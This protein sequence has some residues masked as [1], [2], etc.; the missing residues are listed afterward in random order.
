M[1]V[2]LIACLAAVIF[3]VGGLFA[4]ASVQKPAGVAY[5]T[6][7]TR[8]TP[9]WSWRQ[10]I[11]RTRAAPTNT[12]SMSVSSSNEAMAEDCNVTSAWSYILVDFR[13]SPTADV[14]CDK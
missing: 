7:G 13:D 6:E 12:A 11:S 8:I 3:A 1:R 4:L 2:F 10:M 14:S 5:A 9:S